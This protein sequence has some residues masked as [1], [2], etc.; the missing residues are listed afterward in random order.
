MK[1]K[2]QFFFIPEPIHWDDWKGYLET[3]CSKGM[4]SGALVGSEASP[5]K[6]ASASNSRTKSKVTRKPNKNLK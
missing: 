1:L 2:E 3:D 5:A 6:Q 4:Q